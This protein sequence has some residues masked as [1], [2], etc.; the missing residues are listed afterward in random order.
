MSSGFD[1]HALMG[2][3]AIKVKGAAWEALIGLTEKVRYRGSGEG[4]PPVGKPGSRHCDGPAPPLEPR[5]SAITAAHEVASH[6]ARITATRTS[7]MGEK[8][9][10]L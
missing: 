2:R 8:T 9:S 10:G 6:S 7:R 4:G 3:R 5:G 1:L